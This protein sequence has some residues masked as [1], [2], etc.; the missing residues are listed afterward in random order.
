MPCSKDRGSDCSESHSMLDVHPP[1][2]DNGKLRGR[3]GRNLPF[4]RL[5]GIRPVVSENAVFRTHHLSTVDNDRLQLEWRGGR[6]ED[7]Q[8]M[9]TDWI[10]RLA[11]VVLAMP[12]AV[13]GQAQPTL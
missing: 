4:S 1:H 11:V 5:K 13:L 12:S 2:H 10:G 3:E 8:R 9:G 7:L 6:S